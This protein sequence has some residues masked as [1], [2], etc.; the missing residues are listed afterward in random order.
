MPHP[1]HVQLITPL[2]EAPIKGYEGCM[3]QS[4]LSRGINVTFAHAIFIFTSSSPS[5]SHSHHVLTCT[6]ALGTFG[7]ANYSN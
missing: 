5:W 2:D 1:Q 6:I 4:Y 3:T 7:I